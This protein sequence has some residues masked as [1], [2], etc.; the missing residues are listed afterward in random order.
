MVQIDP[1]P[2]VEFEDR[3]RPVHGVHLLRLTE[4]RRGEHE[5]AETGKKKTTQK[6]GS[7]NVA[8]NLSSSCARLKLSADG[9]VLLSNLEGDSEFLVGRVQPALELGLFLCSDGFKNQPHA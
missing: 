7:H 9:G 5:Q 3:Q 4:R 1:E 8:G 2:A 6:G